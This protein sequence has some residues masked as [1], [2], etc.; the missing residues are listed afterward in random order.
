MATFAVLAVVAA[1]VG[2]YASLTT[3]PKTTI[4]NNSLMVATKV[5]LL[6]ETDVAFIGTVTTTETRK[7]VSST[8]PGEEDILTRAAFNVDRFIFNPHHTT[9]REISLDFLGGTVGKDTLMVEGQE[10]PIVGERMV[11]FTKLQDDGS[12]KIQMPSHGVYHI[13]ENGRLG[14]GEMEKSV[15]QMIFGKDVSVD[16]LEAMLAE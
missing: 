1:S 15:A 6:K 4:V 3:E 5:D 8:R 10:L 2:L 13:D 14:V 9:N 7:A 16:Q 12:L 11:I